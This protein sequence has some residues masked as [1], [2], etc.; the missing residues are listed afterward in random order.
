VA[1]SI[2]KLNRFHLQKKLLL[3]T[4]TIQEAQANL[5]ALIHDLAAGEEL[6]ILEDDRPIA[7]LI[8]TPSQHAPQPRKPSSL[9]GTVR[10]MAPDFDAPLEDLKDYME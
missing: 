3:A 6:I 8:P 10:Y 5:A 2:A 9:Q 4:V 7:K 1:Q